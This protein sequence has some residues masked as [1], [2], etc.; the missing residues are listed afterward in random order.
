M[1]AAKNKLSEEQQAELYREMQN[2]ARREDIFT[3]NDISTFRPVAVL[4]EAD[5]RSQIEWVRYAL[6]QIC[7]FCR[8]SSENRRG[9]YW[10]WEG[11]PWMAANVVNLLLRAKLPL[12]VE[13]FIEILPRIGELESL[14]PGD[15]ATLKKLVKA[16]ESLPDDQKKDPRLAASIRQFQDALLRWG[17]RERRQLAVRLDRALAP[18]DEPHLFSGE[19]WADL[20]MAEIA[21]VERHRSAWNQLLA[22]CESSTAASPATKWIDS[23]LRG[24]GELGWEDFA[25]C[26]IRWFDQVQV[27]RS[28]TD[29]PPSTSIT[30]SELAA[31]QVNSDILKGLVWCCGLRENAELARALTKLAIKSYRKVPGVGPWLVRVGNACVWALGNMPGMEGVT[32]LAILRVRVK[33]G[34]AQ[35]LIEKAL[36]AAAERVGL[37]REDLD[38]MAVPAYGLTEVG[39][40]QENLGECTA[41]IAITSDSRV[42]LSWFKSNGKRV[43]SVPAS[44]RS[45]HAEDLKELKT[46]VK[47]IGVMLS[48]QRERLDQLALGRKSWPLAVWKERYLDHPLVGCVARRLIWRFSRDRQVADA[49]F[50]DGSIIDLN[51]KPVEWLDGGTQVE[52]WHPIQADAERVVAWRDW[53]EKHQIRQPFKQAHREVYLLTDAERQTGT[54]SNRYAAHILR[55]HQFNALCAARGWKNAL[56]LLVDQEFPPAMRHLPQWGLRAEFWIEGAG[57]DYG[58]DTNETGTFYYVNTDQVRFYPIEAARSTAHAWGGRYDTQQAGEPIPLEQ[59]PPLVFSEIMR[60]VDLFVGVASV[61]NDPT[62]QDGGPGGGYRDYWQEYSFG[63]LT[64][65]S[66]T[67]RAVL[68]RLIPR[69]KIADRCSFSERFLLVRG[70]LRRYKI[71]LGSGNILMEPND[72]YLC[73]VARQGAPLEERVFLPFEGDQMLSVI[74]SK[75]MLLAEDTRIKDATILSQ[76]GAR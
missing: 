41:E 38:E 1:A 75:A 61:G 6:R 20:A 56:R 58:H 24:L 54:Y 44:I 60:D 35:K 8:H 62:W 37:P 72:Q 64:E 30:A 47:D 2:L 70:D 51:D 59:V 11:S 74:L 3:E 15:E 71:H 52:L 28:V 63:K 31:H 45:A 9:W 73:I 55:Q 23:S 25:S 14:S 36:H 13:D 46:A 7:E 42:E 76:I 68:Q 17:G 34:T 57:T 50:V 69:L 29:E 49:V 67:R 12:A 19:A 16:I 27:P 53:L 43:K 65:S 21:A 5:A 22:H 18:A 4:L 33:F 66:E 26:V 32:Q 48:V 39:R 40:R 10:N